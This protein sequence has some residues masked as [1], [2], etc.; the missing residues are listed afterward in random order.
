MRRL[1]ASLFALGLVAIGCQSPPPASDPFRR[2]RIPPPATGQVGPVA[3]G[4]YGTTPPPGATYPP[5]AA[6]GYSAGPLAPLAPPPASFAPPAS[7]PATAPAGI[8]SPPVYQPPPPPLPSGPPAGPSAPLYTPPGNGWA[9]TSSREVPPTQSIYDNEATREDLR[10]LGETVRSGRLASAA[11]T[12][13]SSEGA[14]PGE[15]G[16]EPLR[17]LADTAPAQQLGRSRDPAGVVP[18]SYQ[19]PATVPAR[20]VGGVYGPMN[21]S[22][23]QRA[24][25][26]V[27]PAGGRGPADRGATYGYDGHYAWLQGQLEYSEASRQWKLR[28]I[29]I[30]GPTDRYGG[31][32]VLVDSPALASRKAGDFVSIKGQLDE[33][34]KGQAGFAPLYTITSVDRLSD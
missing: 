23:A 25:R 32:V 24:N 31:S 30:D 6:P 14:S 22:G 28:Y 34:G 21:G 27:S 9:P 11:G 13:P 5:P 18:V 12:L 26:V 16:I 29:P 3:V 8:S 15:Q 7:M 1:L 20:T 19:T 2:S 17:G 10:P 33:S 4:T